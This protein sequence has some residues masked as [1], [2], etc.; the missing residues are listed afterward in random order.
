MAWTF[1]KLFRE[2]MFK[3]RLFIF[4]LIYLNQLK[5]TLQFKLFLALDV[6]SYNYVADS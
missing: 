6:L 1:K 2:F 5:S 3:M 4:E